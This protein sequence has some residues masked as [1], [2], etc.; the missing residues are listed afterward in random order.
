MTAV[1]AVATAVTSDGQ[2]GDGAIGFAAAAR[3]VRLPRPATRRIFISGDAVLA[4]ELGRFG[5]VDSGPCCN[6]P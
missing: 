3:A 6:V 2:P 5:Q 1:A 4:I